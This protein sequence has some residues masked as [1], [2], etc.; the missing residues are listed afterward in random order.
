[1]EMADTTS[2]ILQRAST[3]SAEGHA[4]DAEELCRQVLQRDPD[5]V[6][7]IGKLG[8][9][10]VRSGR[11]DEGILSLRKALERDPSSADMHSELGLAL[12]SSGKPE[13]AIAHFEAAAR[14]LPTSPE[15]HF[16]LATALQA[17]GYG[18]QA[19]VA[20]EKTIA[21][22]AEYAEAHCNLGTLL[23]SLE[24]HADAIPHYEKA[25]DV[26]PGYTQ[27][28][29]GLDSAR[30]ALGLGKEAPA[31]AAGA[32]T[33]EAAVAP[34]STGVNRLNQYV[35][36]FLSR[37]NDFRMW[38]YPGL[39]SRPWHDPS[40]LPVVKALEDSF[41]EIRREIHGVTQASY[42]REIERL[43]VAGSWNVSFFYERGKKN[44]ENCQK[45]PVTAAI[46]E[47]HNT[48]RSMVGLNYI[49]KM[50]PGTQVRP[51]RGPTNLR[52][53]CHLGI[54]VPAGDCGIRVGGE[55]RKWVEG[56]CIVFD[57]SF[58]HEAWNRANEDRIVLIVDVWHPDLTPPEIAFLEGLHRYCEHHAK[59]LIRYWNDNAVAKGQPGLVPADM[60][61]RPPESPGAH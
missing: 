57:D 32:V 12:Q 47:S 45:C 30:L 38:K 3:L 8:T 55:T 41:D 49:S 28:R 53:R 6:E 54:D 13:L 59:S 1:M 51:H 27:A 37:Q 4:A 11:S 21:L 44:I 36:L 25:L 60:V 23:Q 19:I 50:A 58:E 24:R 2:S 14:A 48:V 10:L 5:N 9:I 43:A 15:A 7:A 40:A 56:K 46:I 16:C 22:D 52:L 33:R 35:N 34:S 31:S 39:S 17:A 29:A 42:H 61:P 26:D 18:D 20:Y